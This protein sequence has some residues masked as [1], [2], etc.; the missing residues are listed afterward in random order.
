MTSKGK[1]RLK[2]ALLTVVMISLALL[3]SPSSWILPGLTVHDALIQS[4]AIVLLAGNYQE[5]APAAAMLYRDGYA[6]LVI[7]TNDGIFSS[8]SSK[9]GRNLY[10]VEWATEELVKLG[11]PR[12][13]ILQLPF[14]G[15]S[16][17]FDA[18][19]VKRQ[20]S[21]SGLKKIILVTSDYHT[22]RTLWTFKQVLQQCP[23]QLTVYPALS[24]GANSRSLA[25]ECVKFAYY[26]TK[27]GMLGLIPAANEVKPG[28]G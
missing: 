17:L 19:A 13:K 21:K 5:R 27:Y 4:D 11:V 20:L 16:T 18:L 26:L 25:L 10:Q 28:R 15:S 23:T 14:Y 3:S 9:Y 22:R 12:E 24:F 8:W 2:V 1:W 6:P 7:L